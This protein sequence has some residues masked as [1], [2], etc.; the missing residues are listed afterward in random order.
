MGSGD[1]L[2]RGWGKASRELPYEQRP[3]WGRHTRQNLREYSRQ[4]SRQCSRQNSRE[5]PRQRKNQSTAPQWAG[6]V[7]VFLFFN[8]SENINVTI[9]KYAIQYIWYIH[10]IVCL[11]PLSSFKIFSLPWKEALYPLSSYSPFSFPS[12]WQPVVRVPSLRVYLF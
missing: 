5:C 2:N 6:W 10:D 1:I 3:A 4:N 11:L 12:L 8:W 9:L 7:A